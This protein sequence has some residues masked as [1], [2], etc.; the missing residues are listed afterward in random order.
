MNRRS[1]FRRVAGFGLGLLGVKALPE[2]LTT[3]KLQRVAD[4]VDE[5][6]DDEKVWYFCDS[7]P[8]SDKFHCCI[9]KDGELIDEWEQNV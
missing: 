9:Y 4:W 8:Y 3:A 6:A 2:S 7:P 1:F 5:N